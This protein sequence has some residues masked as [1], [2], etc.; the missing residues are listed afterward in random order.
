MNTAHNDASAAGGQPAKPGGALPDGAWAGLHKAAQW[1]GRVALRLPYRVRVHHAERIP[2]SG[3]IVLVANHSSL[4]DGPLLFGM[5]PREAVF[6]IKH[7]MFRGPVGWF[8]RRIGQIPVRR[9]EPDRRPLLTAVQVLRAG[10]LVGVFPEGTRGDGAVETAQN[11]AAWL[12]RTA[13]ARVLPVACRGTRRPEGKRFRFFPRIDV[14]F[15]HP[16]TLPAEKG[17]A[18]LT[19]ATEQLRTELVELIGE[20]DQMIADQRDRRTRGKRA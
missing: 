6:L 10:G 11:G 8:L 13:G 17:R 3:P 20:L 4:L 9:G 16:V 7:E 1:V 19:A 18:G 12:A 15:G 5:L 2:R 14:L